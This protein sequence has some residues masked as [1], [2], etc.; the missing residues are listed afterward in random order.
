VSLKNAQLASFVFMLESLAKSKSCADCHMLKLCKNAEWA[1]SLE[2]DEIGK[3]LFLF[4]TM[5]MSGRIA[6]LCLGFLFVGGGGGGGGGGGFSWQA[7]PASTW[8]RVMIHH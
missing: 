3:E 2:T 8:V 7:E 4:P 1:F 6:R 5:M